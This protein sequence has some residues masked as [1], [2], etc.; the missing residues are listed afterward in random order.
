MNQ[1]ISDGFKRLGVSTREAEKTVRSDIICQVV[2][3]SLVMGIV[4]LATI[5]YVPY[6]PSVLAIGFG[7][8]ALGC[9]ARSSRTEPPSLAVAGIA[10]G[11]GAAILRW[12]MFSP[13]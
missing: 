3:P 13:R 7:V 9:S 1:K 2:L 11:V 12:F 6:L 4:A 10:C 5:G 8:R